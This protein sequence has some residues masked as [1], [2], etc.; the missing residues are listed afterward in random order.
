MEKFIKYKTFTFRAYPNK[1]Q[2][3]LIY[4]T[5]IMCRY[6]FNTLLSIELE[7]LKKYNNEVEKCLKSYKYFDDKKFT[8][9]HKMPKISK[10]KNSNENYKKVDSLAICAEYSN[11]VRGMELFY[12][13]KSNL[14]K[15]KG[16]ND[17]HSYTT[18]QVNNNIRIVNNKIRLPKVG[19]I[20]VRGMREIPSNFKIKRAIIFEDK[21]GK[22]FI[23]IV[24]EYEKID[25]NDDIY[26]IKNENKVVGLDF[27]IGDIFVSSDGFI[28]K[29]SNSYFILLDKIPIIQNYVNRKKKFSKN[30]WKSINKLRKIHRNVVNIRKDMLNKLSYTLSKNYNYVIIE[31]LSIKEIVYKLGR[32]KNAYNTS[33]NSFVKRLLYKFENKVIK[34]NKWFPS[35]KKCSIC[36]KKKKHLRLSQRIY[37]CY[38]CGNIIDRDLNA[39]INIKNEGVRLLN[40]C[41]FEV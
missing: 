28:P 6:M 34:I 4:L 13:G 17:K 27:K 26:S 35:S 2:T 31:D 37:R 19:F 36:G 22:F 11:L 10:L 8:K 9:E 24:F 21:K 12:R 29:Y 41:E 39:A 7:N 16:R 40:T 33:F 30:Y 38:F 32:G 20:K 18:S 23:S 3:N 1:S 25:K 14:P 5:F 15:F